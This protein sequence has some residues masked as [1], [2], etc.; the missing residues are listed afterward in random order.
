MQV[1]NYFQLLEPVSVNCADSFQSETVWNP[2]LFSTLENIQKK[3]LS[4]IK[5]GNWI[6]DLI[7]INEN[8]VDSSTKN[9]SRTIEY[10][11]KIVFT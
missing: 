6:E 3:S 1:Q 9:F 2:W 7:S 11:L 4:S 10:I 5:I 8:Q